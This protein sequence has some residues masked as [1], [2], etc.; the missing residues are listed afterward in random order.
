AE[1]NMWHDPHA[2]DRVFSAD[3]PITMIGLDVTEKTVMQADYLAGLRRSR[4]GAFI[5]DI[6]RFYLEFHQKAHGIY[7][8][9]THDPSAIAYLI[10]PTLFTVQPGPIRV[11]CE[12]IGVGQTLWDR[13]GRQ[14]A[15][16][17]AWSRRRPVHVGI[18]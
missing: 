8:A 13:S 7:A 10:D 12:G 1:A 16:Q 9:Y 15:R 4:T 6:V 14:W 18:E 2:A 11:L 17:N 5:D 3:W